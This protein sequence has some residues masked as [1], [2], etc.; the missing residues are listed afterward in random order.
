MEKPRFCSEREL[1]QMG[2][3]DSIR[4]FS[5][6]WAD[7][8]TS[9]ESNRLELMAL[10]RPIVGDRQDFETI[11]RHQHGVLELSGKLAIGGA[12]SPA[13]S[14]VDFRS[15]SALIQHRLDGETR[16]G[17]DV[18]APS[19][20]RIVRNAGLLM[21]CSADSV[22]L[23]F[24]HDRQTVLLGMSSDGSPDV[25]DSPV[26]TNCVDSDPKGIEGGLN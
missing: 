20:A 1:Y 7:A 3:N 10:L 12:N 25:V 14:L 13:V 6:E 21:E 11:V 24:L 23:V 16:S 5:A 8:T 22:T 15:P 18:D 19:S 4:V 17:F 26:G 2:E 9:R